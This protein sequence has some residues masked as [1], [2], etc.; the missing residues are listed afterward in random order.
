MRPDA[1]GMFWQDLPGGRG[2]KSAEARP[3]PPIPET[4]WLPPTEPP[5]L[6]GVR[7]LGVDTET[8]DPELEENGPGWARHKGQIAG[9]SLA[10]S[11]VDRWYFPLRHTIEP[12]HNIDPERFFDWLRPFMRDHRIA[13]VGANLGYDC[14]WLEEEGVAVRGDLY[15][16]QFAEA[17]LTENERVGLDYLGYKYLAE[18]KLTSVLYQWCS[19]AYGGQPND[20]QRK[21]I[22][23]APPRLVGPYAETDAAHPLRIMPLQW[24]LLEREGLTQVFRMECDLIYLI[25]A[26]RFKGISV[27][28]DHAEEMSRRLGR[29]IDEQTDDLIRQTGMTI[30]VDAASDIAAVFD[31]FQIPYGKTRTGK[32][33]FTKDF[34]EGVEHPIGKAITEIRKLRK[35]KGT[36]IDG[37]I[38]GSHV[39]GKI[40]CSFNL[41]RGDGYGARSGRLSSD[42]PNLQNI[43]IRTELGKELRKV[44]KHDVE[45]KQTRK[46]DYSQIEYRFLSHYAIGPR[47]DEVRETYWRDPK[48]DYHDLVIRMIKELTGVTLER[49]PAK[50]I[51][52]GLVY[53]MS[54]PKLGRDLHLSPAQA[55]ELFK[56]YHTGAPFVRVTMRATADEAEQ[57]GVITTILNRRS[58]FDLWEPAE[59]SRGAD[60]KPGLPYEMAIRSYGSI[61]RAYLH[62]AINR[63]LQ[64]SAADL[65]KYAMWKC[66]Y[67]GLYDVTGVPRLQVHDELVFSD[68][69]G[70]DPAFEEVFRTMETCMHLRVPIRV[71]TSAGVNWGSTE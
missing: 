28:L 6:S 1:I 66:Y 39:N 4:G 22:Y 52:F 50:N 54:E 38:L 10:V 30:S 37:Y 44:F 18:G 21:N 32:P 35:L 11:P 29:M 15:D 31:K 67:D 24:P 48:T 5:N 68:P 40:H 59:R 34:L 26:M 51:N 70:V 47:A 3:T 13:K 36:F 46:V 14:G 60:R 2:K 8:Y 19:D 42:S 25:N 41:L 65:I 23:R 7:F 17:L 33:S 9:V 57:T 55:K 61:K 71:D 64:G 58:R 12:H 53:G 20:R 45:H 27:D 49:R 16:V 43:P 56:A 62:K 63:R 69:G